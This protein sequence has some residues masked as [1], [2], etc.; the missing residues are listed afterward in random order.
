M[1]RERPQHGSRL[2][3]VSYASGTGGICQIGYAAPYG[4]TDPQLEMVNYYDDYGFISND[5]ANA[6]PT[7]NIDATQEQHATGSLTGRVVYAT[8][9]EALG[10]VNVY[11]Q[12]GQVVR[13]VG[14]RLGGLV[15][16]VRTAYSFTGAV[17]TVQVDVNVGYGGS[18]VATTVYTYDQESR[19]RRF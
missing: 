12:K 1:N 3:K 8:D 10:T 9:G 16:D 14:K 13:C 11:D 6:I 2:A 5:F 4:I 7:V 17:D 19:G 15:E 18:L